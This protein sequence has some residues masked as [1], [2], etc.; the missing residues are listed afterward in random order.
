MKTD[1]RSGKSRADKIPGATAAQIIPEVAEV[2]SS[3]T[4]MQRS[5][6]WVVPRHDA[7]IKWWKRAIIKYLPPVRWWYRAR[8]MDIREGFYH[9]VT[10]NASP[11]AQHMRELNHELMRKGLPNRPEMW[12]KLTP[13]YSPGC[14]RS[15]VSDDYYPTL[16]RPNVFLETRDLKEVISTGLRVGDEGVEIEC[17]AIILATGFQTMVRRM[18]EP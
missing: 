17:D 1:T 4:V 11:A 14:K 10:N 5:P 6:G 8:M 7:P 13:R 2:A 9:A 12:E 16:N 18:H 3:L 15:V